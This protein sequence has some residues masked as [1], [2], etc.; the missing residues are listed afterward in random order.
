MNTSSSSPPVRKMLMP[1]LVQSEEILVLP[2]WEMTG[3]THHLTIQAFIHCLERCWVKLV[4]L[5]SFH[6]TMSHTSPDSLLPNN[7]I[8]ADWQNHQCEILPCCSTE[9]SPVTVANYTNP[10]RV[11]YGI[12]GRCIYHIEK[13]TVQVLFKTHCVLTLIY[14][15]CEELKRIIWKSSNS[16]LLFVDCTKRIFV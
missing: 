12:E 7:A 1:H 15:V 5:M 4:L 13:N 14:S 10:K 6:T 11:E 8:C 16:V 3:H 9:Y 2:Q